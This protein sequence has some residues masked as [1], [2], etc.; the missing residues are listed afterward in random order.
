MVTRKKRREVVTLG[1]KRFSRERL[2]EGLSNARRRGGG[3]GIRKGFHWK[4]EKKTR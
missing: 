4:V 3:Q 2:E 1:K